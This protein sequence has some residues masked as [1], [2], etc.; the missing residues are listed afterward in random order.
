MRD[1]IVFPGWTWGMFGSPERVSLALAQ[2]GAKVLYCDNPTSLFR[3]REP[4]QLGEVAKNVYVMRP[5]H[6]GHRL[7]YFPPLQKM[8]AKALAGQMTR[9]AS[10]LGLRDPIF[11]YC[12]LGRVGPV[13][14]E[15][16]R[17]FFS[18][19]LR[20]DYIESNADYF[21]EISDATL[22]IPRSVFHK[23]KAKFGAKVKLIP[24]GVDLALLNPD[25]ANLARGAA[26]MASIPGPHLGYLG[27]P[28]RRLNGPVLSA[29]LQAHPEWHFV[30]T[31]SCP[32]PLP[33]AH[34]VPRVSPQELVGYLYGFDV[35]FLPYDCHDEQ[36]LHCVPLKLFE[37]FALGMPVVSTPLLNLW[38]Y[39]DLI[40]FGDTAEELAVAIQAALN[41]PPDSPKRQKRMEVARSHSLENL[42][43]VLRQVLPLDEGGKATHEDAGL[44]LPT[45]LL[46]R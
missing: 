12:N 5:R 6:W 2:L 1:A 19:Y 39:E 26:E 41:E 24:Q 20:V 18:V 27:P 28:N 7:N 32:V 16:K 10:T 23:L 37:Y 3:D 8:Q 31:E 44:L 35:G 11:L 42:A 21:A 4:V 36:W 22:A 38:E 43:Q 15:M 40:Y 29:L 45:A 46:P 17:K 9:F 14:S 13:C 30:S 33:N 25:P 34:A